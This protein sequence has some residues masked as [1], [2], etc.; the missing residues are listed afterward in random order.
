MVVS[1]TDRS[2]K[3]KAVESGARARTRKLMLDAAI[4]LMQ[5]GLTPSVN[6]VASV[7]GVSRATA[8]RYFASEAELVHAVVDEALGPILDWTPTGAS[9]SERVSDLLAT[10][11]P[12]IDEFEAT[13]K[14]SLR[15]SLEQWAKR[16]A[17]TLGAEPL[18]TRGHRI[19]LMMNATA[20][21]SGTV[22]PAQHLRLAQALSLVYGVEV[23][24][25]LK[26]I[27]GLN[28]T[29]AQGVAQWA[30]AALIKAAEA[31]ANAGQSGRNTAAFE[32]TKDAAAAPARKGN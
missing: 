29:E 2:R 5:S 1:K 20:P 30:A 12:R 19:D 27:W 7:A 8:Y 18:F 21:L 9:V 10:A 13:F 4:E 22:T 32:R 24:N 14:A 6:G 25:V 17:G 31:E 26:D 11:I 16:R 3:P 15:L 23:L 28:A